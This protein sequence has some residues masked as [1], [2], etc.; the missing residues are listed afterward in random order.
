[1]GTAESWKSTTRTL[2]AVSPDMY[3]QARWV[4][5][6]FPRSHPSCYFSSKDPDAE[7]CLYCT[8][9]AKDIG[10]MLPPQPTKPRD[11][12]IR[13]MELKIQK[14][15]DAQKAKFTHNK[16]QSKETTSD[17]TQSGSR[18]SS[19][20][21]PSSSSFK[22]I[23][24]KN[25][26]QIVDLGNILP[27]MSIPRKKKEKPESISV[28][29]PA[30]V[31]GQPSQVSA[32]A[33][34]GRQWGRK[35]RDRFAELDS[36]I[37]VAVNAG[38][39]P[40]LKNSRKELAAQKS[41]V[42]ADMIQLVLNDLL[43]KIKDKSERGELNATIKGRKLFWKREFSELTK[44][45]F[46][47]MWDEVKRKYTLVRNSK[48][49]NTVAT[50]SVSADSTVVDGAAEEDED[51]QF[52]STSPVGANEEEAITT[53]V[54]PKPYHDRWSHLFVGPSFR[55]GNEFTLDDFEEFV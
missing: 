43:E 24:R 8:T 3:F 39:R 23:K 16:G 38:D 52:V 14:K 48:T 21:I 13:L 30:D 20:S 6:L 42:T 55:M 7:A 12:K 2:V 10:I 15:S 54:P 25:V 47:E 4:C 36:S 31:V 44:D 46:K 50:T 28:S 53:D 32:G 29:K 34:R 26:S 51:T 33:R 27:S 35:P 45:D 19:G 1:M 49:N 41:K 40:T 9:H 18:K 22:S 37:A 17:K 5:D 11:L